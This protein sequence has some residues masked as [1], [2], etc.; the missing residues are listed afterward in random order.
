MV[1]SHNPEI[2]KWQG[3]GMFSLKLSYMPSS[4]ERGQ[5]RDERGSAHFCGL[6]FA[7]AT[8]QGQA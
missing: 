6:T 3:V 5:S 1:Q 2:S 8:S 7:T 4:D